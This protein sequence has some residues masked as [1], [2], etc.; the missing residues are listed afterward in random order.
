MSR[1]KRV[2]PDDI[3][4]ELDETARTLPIYAKLS[5][6]FTEEEMFD[7]YDSFADEGFRLVEHAE[8]KIMSGSHKSAP[9]YLFKKYD[10]DKEDDKQLRN[11]ML[12]VEGARLLRTFIAER[13][14]TDVVAPRKWL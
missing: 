10:N 9:G 2:I 3:Q 11:Y 8:H 13:G 14:F 4:R 6:L 5:G 12:R 1:R 7:S